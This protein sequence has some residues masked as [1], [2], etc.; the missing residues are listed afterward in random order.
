MSIINAVQLLTGAS[1]LPTL[2]Y[3][4]MATGDLAE[5]AGYYAVN[6]GGGGVFYYDSGSSATV[7]SG[8][9]FNA[10]PGGRWLRVMAG[11]GGN[12]STP[13]GPAGPVSVKWWGAKGNGQTGDAAT[14]AT[15]LNAAIAY[16]YAL[17][18]TSNGAKCSVLIPSGSY[19]INS[20]VNVKGDNGSGVDVLGEGIGATVVKA[21]SSG[22]TGMAIFSA[23][24]QSGASI[25]RWAFKQMTIDGGGSGNGL[26]A[27]D[28]YTN[29]NSGTGGSSSRGIIQEV[30]AQNASYGIKIY[31]WVNTVRDCQVL[32]CSTGIYLQSA[33]SCVV[34]RC[35]ANG[36]TIP[37]QLASGSAVFI[38]ATWESNQ[39]PVLLDGL[40]GATLH[41]CYSESNGNDT[42]GRNTQLVVGETTQCADIIIM[43]GYFSGGS[44][45]TP[46]VTNR[47]YVFEFVNVEGYSVLHPGAKDA[48]TKGRQILR[49]APPPAGGWG[50]SPSLL[51][52][53][54]LSPGSQL[55]PD[56]IG[57]DQLVNYFPNP[58]FDYGYS[59]ALAC[60]SSVVISNAT[61]TLVTNA[62]A[63]G[64]VR[65]GKYSICLQGPATPAFG[66]I[67][68]NLPASIY[69]NLSGQYVRV[70]ALVK[71]DGPTYASGAA[72]PFIQMNS[73][74]SGLTS[75]GVG[76][77][78]F[79]LVSAP[80]TL[81]NP[82]TS[83][84]VELGT[85]S[86]YGGYG[87]PIGS[88]DFIYLD[89]VWIVPGNVSL[90]S[91]LC[92]NVNTLDCAQWP[93]YRQN[94]GSPSGVLTPL[95]VGEEVLDT[96]NNVWYKAFNTGNTN[97][98]L[99]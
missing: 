78:W 90:Q 56:A 26:I 8:A 63:P 45:P 42:N 55:S 1:G 81:A 87:T 15:A 18:S 98:Q 69:G 35:Y 96:T 50:P 20:T 32:G 38:N 30:L 60:Y 21:V 40:S 44:V 7:D 61:D 80:T 71:C 12:A 67:K 68:F 95:F 84:Y 85:C 17:N 62:T 89:S 64:F 23:A 74:S 58:N 43:G 11:L 22:F 46:P 82:L 19:Y 72:T 25:Q 91:L 31:G 92:G 70:V 54:S 93:V 39:G 88:S 6:D 29:T 33:N 3:V 27:F 52:F 99:L 73:T 16:A 76:P 65:Y 94:A 59:S 83:L 97:W 47:L 13:G 49:A 75:Y 34:E 10:A 9:V 14:N 37:M 28:F 24:P 77:D 51:A 86:N 5:V 48:S 41:N 4:G 2:N 79:L 53:R 57:A 66:Y 36:N